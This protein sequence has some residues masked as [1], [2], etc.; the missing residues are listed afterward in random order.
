MPA[1]KV[2]AGAA[3]K[4]ACPAAARSRRTTRTCA[5]PRRREISCIGN[6]WPA[7]G[8]ETSW[9][10]FPSSAGAG[11]LSRVSRPLRYSLGVL[12]PRT[13]NA[14]RPGTRP[15]GS[16][17]SCT[18]RVDGGGWEAVRRDRV[19]EA[20]SAYSRQPNNCLYRVVQPGADRGNQRQAYQIRKSRIASSTKPRTT[21]AQIAGPAAGSGCPPGS[22]FTPRRYRASRQLSPDEIAGSRTGPAR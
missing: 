14:T 7:A 1:R 6:R 13:C 2:R 19:S 5:C 8:S 4:P 9:G 20:N 3:P 17:A 12:D 10:P 21:K 22:C 18:P 11:P 16:V 15:S